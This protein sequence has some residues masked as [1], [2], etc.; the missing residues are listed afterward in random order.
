[1]QLGQ[2]CKGTLTGDYLNLK[3]IDGIILST[4]VVVIVGS[5]ITIALTVLLTGSNNKASSSVS[6]SQIS[7]LDT[8]V[9]AANPTLSTT[10]VALTPP[11]QTTAAAGTAEAS[12]TSPVAVGENI[13]LPFGNRLSI[14]M[15]RTI[16][17]PLISLEQ[18]KK[19]IYNEGLDF[20]VTGILNGKVVTLDAAYG[21]VTLGTKNTGGNKQGWLG[22]Q[23]IPVPSCDSSGKCNPTDAILN[24]VE[25]RPMWVLDFGNT[26]FPAAGVP[27]TSNPCPTPQIFNHSVYTVDAISGAVFTAEF[28]TR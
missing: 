3:K 23:N 26:D 15:F 6:L 2:I 17:P 9:A 25:N 5:I 24:H 1:M 21:L 8:P 14:K 7:R 20:S 27:C 22:P 16:D 11:G 10:T 19:A 18:A 28:Y 13:P 4:I 12:T